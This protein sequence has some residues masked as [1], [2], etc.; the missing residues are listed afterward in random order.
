[1][2]DFIKMLHEYISDFLLD[3]S[4][5]VFYAFLVIGIGI[6]LITINASKNDDINKKVVTVQQ[7]SDKVIVYN[8]AYEYNSYDVDY[9][10]DYELCR[11]TITYT[12]AE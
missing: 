7:T 2:K 5:G 1:M 8:P 11:I 6:I 3:H 10:E 9:T 12:K 4:V